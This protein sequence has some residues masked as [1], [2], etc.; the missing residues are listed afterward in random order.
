MKLTST[1][2]IDNS[3][4]PTKHGFKHGNISPKLLIEDIPIKTKS[5]VLIMDDPDAMAAVGKIWTHW[6]V[7]NISPKTT[8][9]PENSLPQNS[10]EGMS[11]FGEIGYGGPAPPDQEHTYY[12]RLF[13]IDKFLNLSQGSLKKDVVNEI[14]NHIIEECILKGKY[15][16]Q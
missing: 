7:W 15:T 10:I 14:Q 5:L 6:I 2:F 3:T 13:A 11:D 4:I 12:F 16:P 8:E 9:I 1:S